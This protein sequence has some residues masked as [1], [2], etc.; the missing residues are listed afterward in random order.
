M[1]QGGVVRDVDDRLE[2]YATVGHVALFD[3]LNHNARKTGGDGLGRN[4]TEVEIPVSVG[5]RQA[6]LT[7]G[8]AG[9]TGHVADFSDGDKERHQRLVG[10]R[11]RVLGV[12][13]LAAD[14]EPGLAVALPAER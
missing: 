4:A 2:R 12:A 7:V 10:D 14:V 1:G 13:Q 9:D 3:V 11:C 6:D 8:R 5:E